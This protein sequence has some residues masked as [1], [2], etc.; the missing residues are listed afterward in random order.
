MA[1]ILIIDDEE[2]TLEMFSLMLE[3]YGYK[4]LSARDGEEGLALLRLFA[5]PILPPVKVELG[6][7]ESIQPVYA[8]AE[9]LLLPKGEAKDVSYSLEMSE[10]VAAPVS[11]GDVL[12]M[13]TVSNSGGVLAQIDVVAADDVARL[14]VW[15]IF[16]RLL[17]I[18]TSSA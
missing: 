3:A 5:D 17:G 9:A 15:G 1:R 10:T 18:V 14:S 6:E 11:A 16:Y 12:G 4:V 13:L 7:T 2:P 8:G